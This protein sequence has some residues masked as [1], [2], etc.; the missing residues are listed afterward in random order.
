[1][2]STHVEGLKETHDTKTSNT[3][4]T[5]LKVKPHLIAAFR[6]APSTPSDIACN[7]FSVLTVSSTWYVQH[8]SIFLI[9]DE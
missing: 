7:L 3:F 5:L 8:V 6:S 4:L 9:I 2:H 1:M